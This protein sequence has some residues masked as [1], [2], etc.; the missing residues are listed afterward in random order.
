MID[1]PKSPGGSG[2]TST[3]PVS[4]LKAADLARQQVNQ[5]IQ[6]VV[7]EA[8]LAQASGNHDKAV[9]EILLRANAAAASSPPLAMSAKAA[10]AAAQPL[11]QISAEAINQLR[12]GQTLLIRTHAGFPIAEG[13]QLLAT[14]SP[15]RGIVINQIL[16]AKVASTIT[17]AL[18]QLVPQQQGLNPLFQLLEQISARPLEPAHRGALNLPALTSALLQLLPKPEQLKTAEQVRQAINNSGLFLE[19]KLYQAVRSN[20]TASATP[21]H[22]GHST[23]QTLGDGLRQLSQRVIDAVGGKATP[24][25]DA[26][27]PTGAMDLGNVAARDLKQAL[28]HLQGRLEQAESALK[29]AAATAPT[30]APKPAPSEPGAGKPLAVNPTGNA[31]PASGS[32]EG[33]VT[34]TG[35]PLTKTDAGQRGTTT[36]DT[37]PQPPGSTAPLTTPPIK[38][39]KTPGYGSPQGSPYSD[40]SSKTA[41]ETF[42]LPPLPGNIALQPQARSKPT[43][44]G[45]M[46]DALVSVL[47]KQVKGALSR[48][49]LHQLASQPRSPDPAAPQPLLSFEL[50]VLHQGQVQVFQFVIEEQEART[51]QDGNNTGK[52]WVVQM[53]FDIEGLGPMLCQISML[54]RSASVAF[55]AEWENTLQHTRSH[56]E[57]L[58]NV[59]TDMGLRVEKLQGHLGMPKSE[60]AILRNQLVDI[61]T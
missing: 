43:S 30:P 2:Q 18:R 41:V 46:A 27:R 56:F 35:T 40:A 21:S 60:Q 47:L 44:G 38:A 17:Q 28:H 55:W 58:Q 29:Q 13:T 57:Y 19:N 5:T 52:R 26:S 54:G 53:A 9:Y 1:L 15:I 14:A 22:P 6:A 59:L 16:P 36:A 50:P 3:S 31:G 34:T 24:A 39:D 20:V 42:L 4:E 37:R 45:D 25:A 10:P 51:E 11:T 61:R 48:I 23:A 7:L 8:K 33:A 32:N 12:Q 49:T